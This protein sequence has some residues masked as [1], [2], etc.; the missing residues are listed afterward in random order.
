MRAA[1]EQTNIHMIESEQ[2]YQFQCSE[3][4]HDGES[5]VGTRELKH[6]VILRQ[7]S[8]GTGRQVLRALFVSSN[9]VSSIQRWPLHRAPAIPHSPDSGVEH[10]LSQLWQQCARRNYR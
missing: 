1:R 7:D 9:V 4:L 5:E 6:A 2:L 8:S 10:R 3:P